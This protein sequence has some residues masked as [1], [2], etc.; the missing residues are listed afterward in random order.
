M[1]RVA[2]I[3]FWWGQWPEDNPGLGKYYVNR[4]KE[5]V[6]RHTTIPYDF[7]VYVDGDK[8]RN[9]SL[10]NDMTVVP[11]TKE[12]ESYR[13][14][15]KKMNMFDI[16]AAL[17][18]YAWVVA[19]DLDIVITDSIDFLLAHRS[20]GLVTCR[21]A[22]TDGI[23]G[24]IVGFSPRAFWTN[25]LVEYLHDNYAKVE[26]ETQ[27]SER[28]FYQKFFGDD[29]LTSMVTFWQD[30]YPGKVLSYK[31]DKY[32]NGAAIVRFHGRP[33]PH[34]VEQNYSWIQEHWK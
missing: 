30:T 19:L 14:N 18:T 3:C 29:V 31:L 10:L 26:K 11:L 23:G 2:V 1:N 32:K 7:L 9:V 15:L 20:N 16:S 13:W 33:R 34:E 17:H 28:K 4:L 12:F 8:Y 5:S 25:F 21:G 22:Y 27:G 6:A 24:S